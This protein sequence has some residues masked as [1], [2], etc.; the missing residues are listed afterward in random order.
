MS[1]SATE[2]TRKNVVP[3][4]LL[5]LNDGEPIPGKTRLQKLVFLAQEGGLSDDPVDPI[6]EVFEYDPHK[7]GPFSKELAEKLDELAQKGYVKVVEEPTKGGNTR[8]EYE[9]TPKGEDYL[10][11]N[12]GEV[13]IEE[14]LSLKVIKKLHNGMP[15]FELLDKVYADY[16]DYSVNSQLDI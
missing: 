8:N 4:A 16:P 5:K 1:T 6:R 2:V 13:D 12:L 3:L 15:L 10:D 9:L 11:K 14:F 7:Y